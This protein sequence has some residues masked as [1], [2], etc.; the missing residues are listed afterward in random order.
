MERE[1]NNRLQTGAYF[2]YFLVEHTRARRLLSFGY[3]YIR[4]HTLPPY[5]PPTL[6]SVCICAGEPGQPCPSYSGSGGWGPRRD[7]G[8]SPSG[9]SMDPRPGSHPNREERS[10]RD[11]SP[12]LTKASRRRRRPSRL[13][14]LFQIE[15]VLT[16][17]SWRRGAR[18]EVEGTGRGTE[19]SA[20]HPPDL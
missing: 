6:P 11:R 4:E 20:P 19:S 14:R 1:K 13:K 2:E 3:M 8:G 17:R 18:E 10:S 7:G 9:T 5:H 12:N 15:R 16:R